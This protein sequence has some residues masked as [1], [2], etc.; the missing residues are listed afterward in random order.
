VNNMTDELQMVR[1]LLTAPPP[2]AEVTSS[3]RA[4]LMATTAGQQPH[5]PRR[6]SARLLAG[7]PRWRLA[8]TALATAAAVAVAATLLTSGQGAGRPPAG[9]GTAQL[10]ARDVLLT[11][12]TAAAGAD[13]VPSTGKY[14]V[15]TWVSG[16]LL[17]AGPNS[18][19][20][21][22]EQREGVSVTWVPTAPGEA[23]N[24]H[25]ADY[26]SS[27]PTSGARAAWVADGSP[28]LPREAGQR[29]RLTKYEANLELGNEDLTFA[30]WRALPSSAAGLKQAIINGLRAKPKPGEGDQPGGV[31]GITAECVGLIESAMV[32]PAVRAAAFRV[33][34]TMPDIGLMGQVTDPLG[35]PGYGITL[36]GAGGMSQEQSGG[37]DATRSAHRVL[38]ISLSGTVLAEEYFTAAPTTS[39]ISRMPASGAIPGPAACQASQVRLGN[40]CFDLL[41]SA[42]FPTSS[43]SAKG[44]EDEPGEALSGPALT[45]GNPVLAVPAGTLFSYQAFLASG[46][47][48][49]TPSTAVP[50]LPSVSP[51]SAASSPAAPA[52]SPGQS[53]SP[54]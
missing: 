36:P 14:G 27:L 2:T 1:D 21:V 47:T 43:S 38:V 54:S 41:K 16:D 45:L 35:R 15:R 5:R 10:T 31:I 13:A 44:V 51:S 11:A 29:P 37:N 7:V 34:A 24:Y 39:L 53:A 22:I 52:T 33:L 20:Y 46:L 28:A 4:R 25:S 3:A 6:R 12:A 42:P 26:T 9:G 49:A 50:T 30:Q 40:Q 23:F 19:P 18:R 8:V 48:S 17:A 32:T